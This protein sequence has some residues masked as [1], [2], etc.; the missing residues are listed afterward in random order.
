VHEDGQDAVYTELL[1][2]LKVD[3]GGLYALIADC[4][5][6]F[7]FQFFTDNRAKFVSRLLTAGLRLPAGALRTAFGDL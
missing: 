7:G 5:N 3:E 6:R 4:T 2:A 1:P